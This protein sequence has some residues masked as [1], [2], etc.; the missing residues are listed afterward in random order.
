M[1][2]VLGDLLEL[3]DI[4]LVKWMLVSLEPAKY[5]IK[6]EE[7]LDEPEKMPL[8]ELICDVESHKQHIGDARV[9]HQDQDVDVEY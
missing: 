8:H 7:S 1:Y 2:V 4:G 9:E 5:E 3:H 6:V